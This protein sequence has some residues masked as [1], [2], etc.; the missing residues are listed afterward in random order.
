MNKTFEALLRGYILFDVNGELFLT[1]N[2]AREKRLS[3]KGDV[4]FNGLHIFKGWQGFF[5]RFGSD[6]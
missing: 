3:I 6:V 4:A 2:Q 5:V 1:Y